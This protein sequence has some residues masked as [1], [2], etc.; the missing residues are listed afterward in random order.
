MLFRS[1]LAPFIRIFQWSGL[2]PF[3]L[4]TK[5][6]ESFWRSETLKFTTITVVNLIINI[7]P[8]VHNLKRIIYNIR[9]AVGHSKLFAYT[10]WLIGFACR[11]NAI[12]VLIESYSMRSFRAEMLK[13]FD[14][15]ESVFTE[16][17]NHDIEKRQLRTRFFKF[18]IFWG[19][20]IASLTVL[21]ML[22]FSFRS[23][24]YKLYFEMVTVAPFYTSALFYAQW[25]VYV[26]VIR[27]NIERLNECLIKIRDDQSIDQLPTNGH[28][29]QVIPYSSCEFDTCEKLTHL[30]KC[31]SK[32]WRAS[33]LIGRCSR[34]SLLIANGNDLYLLVG[35]LY[36]ILCNMMKTNHESWHKIAFGVICAGMISTN[37]LII[38]IM[39]EDINA[40]VS[41]Y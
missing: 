31:F 1:V 28:I 25:M 13:T 20:R 2:S 26:D 9:P 4:V 18:I 19:V 8:G 16:K 40:K 32:I 17:L 23:S 7:V 3:S 22:S 14:D 21:V 39:C 36:W 11:I 37:F 38:S 41:D 27:F 15:I 35:N 33:L 34:W 6:S 29:F 12:T 30:R 5:K 24:W 10:H